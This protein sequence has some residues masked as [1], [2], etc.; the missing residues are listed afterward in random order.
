MTPDQII[1]L[2]PLAL[3]L[4]RLVALGLVLAFLLLADL[5]AQRWGSSARQ[6]AWLA[7]G[8]GLLAARGA[9]VWHHRESFALEPGAVFKVWLGGWDWI[10]GL[11]AAA[12]VLA[13]CLRGARGKLAGLTIVALMAVIWWGF[14]ALGDDRAPRRLPESFVLKMADGRTLA[15]ADLAGQPLVLNLWASWCPPCRREM[16]ML[17]DAARNARGAV[18]LLV[19]Q[20][21]APATVRT[22][23]AAQRLDSAPVALDAQQRLADFAAAKAF[24]TTL[25]V[26]RD[27]AI[28]HTHVGEISRVQ[29]DIALRALRNA[30]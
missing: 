18:I 7:F 29:L 2:G 3:A 9:Y 14:L 11:A 17:V 10:A 28:R 16:P 5:A 27:G 23:L 15:R 24:P 1:Q 12:C 22:F 21:E 6:P 25:F 30:E 8:L 20:G 26:G 4:D 13:L 19:N